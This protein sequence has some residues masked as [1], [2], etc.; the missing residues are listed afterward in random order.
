MV[1]EKNKK[2]P[3]RWPGLWRLELPLFGRGFSFN[4]P[5]FLFVRVVVLP[6]LVVFVT[7]RFFV[8]ELFFF[9]EFVLVRLLV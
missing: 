4:P 6:L 9:I 7:V 2:S 5:L 8:L 1:C 3:A